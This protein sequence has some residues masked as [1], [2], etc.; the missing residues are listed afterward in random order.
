M[1][2]LSL[3]M[4]NLSSLFSVPIPVVLEGYNGLV[5]FASNYPNLHSLLIPF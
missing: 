5:S 4:D 1:K 3:S 2:T